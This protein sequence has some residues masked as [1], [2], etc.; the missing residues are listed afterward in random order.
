[1]KPPL[2][3]QPDDVEIGSVSS[4]SGP[5]SGPRSSRARQVR[6][7]QLTVRHRATGLEVTGEVVAGNYSR[8]QMIEET[9]KL[10]LRLMAELE[11]LVAKRL[12]VPG[13]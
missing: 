11:K 10:K 13:R 7:T 4:A 8:K 12:R 9:D 6:N 5:P 2:R 3:L 1:M